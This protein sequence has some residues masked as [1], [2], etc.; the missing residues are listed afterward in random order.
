MKKI[1]VLALLSLVLVSCGTKE[2]Q[3][4]SV[5]SRT[6]GNIETNK[7]SEKIQIAAT[8]APIASI[9]NYIWWDEVEAVSIIPAWV[10]PH[11]F[12]LTPQNLISL[13]KADYIFSIWLEHIDGFLEKTSSSN[14]LKLADWINLLEAEEHEHEDEHEHEKEIHEHEEHKDW[15]DKDP[16]IWLG[17]KNLK[18]I[19]EKIANKLAELKPEKK[20]FFN[21]NKRKFDNEIN[22]IFSDFKKEF[23]TKNP[24]H[25]I[26]FHDAYNYLLQDL[27]ISFDK[28]IVF[29]ENFSGEIWANH[30]KELL[31]EIKEHNVKIIFKEPQFSSTQIENLAKE[32]KI[33][34][35]TLD[36]I[37]PDSS[38]NWFIENLKNNLESL[39]NIY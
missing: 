35:L 20:D 24:N 5:N 34:L 27:N 6:T 25:F 33:T 1:F 2:N 22:K 18:I 30:L 13:E 38:S 12:D 29:S 7:K 31:D 39:K 15:H 28:K 10:S 9:V 26:V 4:S 3:N 17:E 23:A 14:I 37:W 16:H 32:N 11:H 19:S 21:E 8:I 36:P